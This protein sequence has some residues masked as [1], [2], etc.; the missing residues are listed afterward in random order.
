MNTAD[1]KKTEISIFNSFI[2]KVVHSLFLNTVGHSLRM[3]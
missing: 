3:A 2:F 1:V